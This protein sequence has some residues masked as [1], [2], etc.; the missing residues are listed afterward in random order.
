M[1]HSFSAAPLKARERQMHQTTQGE[2]AASA[3]LQA[4]Q[5]K[6]FVL[7]D[8]PAP[9]YVIAGVKPQAKTPEAER[10]RLLM[11]IGSLQAEIGKLQEDLRIYRDGDCSQVH[12]HGMRVELVPCE[13]MGVRVTYQPAAE[14]G[15]ESTIGCILIGGMW[16]DAEWWLKPERLAEL[17]DSLEQCLESEGRDADEDNAIERGR[18]GADDWVRL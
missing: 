17:Q 3:G 5:R 2:R 7:Q 13:E 4:L 11:Q 10:A 15:D 14:A 12:Q 6:G 1:P 8:E 16:L 18:D 9:A